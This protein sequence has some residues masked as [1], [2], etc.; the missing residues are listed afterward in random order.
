[1]APDETTDLDVAVDTT[2]LAPGAYRAIVVIQTNDPDHSVTQVPVTL[3][4]PG[5]QQGINVGGK[6]YTT[7]AGVDYADD[8][9][10][11]SGPY[12]YVGAGSKRKTSHSIA[13]TDDDPLYRDQRL[14]M[15][16]YKF[17]VPDGHY[18]VDLQFAELVER[19][20]GRRIFNVTIEGVPV[21]P[22]L[23]VAAEAPGRYVALDRSFEV[24]VSDGQLEHRL[25][26][27]RRRQG[28]RQ[29]DPR[30]RAP[31]R[32]PGRLI[33]AHPDDRRT[34]AAHPSG[35]SLVRA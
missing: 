15:K 2:G 29:R 25:R 16:S 26:G 18:R 32:Q 34:P 17:D 9:S 5:Y 8:R 11:G 12:G 22:Y 23:D 21:I 33:A 24:D 4:V 6:A 28:D 19:R 20:A 14:G 7:A 31:A 1:M 13:G 35:S 3:V 10:Y 30:D 27:P